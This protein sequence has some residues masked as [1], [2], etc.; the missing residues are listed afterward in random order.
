M[1]RSIVAVLLAACLLLNLCPAV[2]AAENYSY[3]ASDREK[4]ENLL[5]VFQWYWTDTYSSADPGQYSYGSPVGI[6]SAI[7]QNPLAVD[8]SQYPVA[9]PDLSW[10]ARTDPLKKWGGYW[11]FD[12]AAV[13][14]VLTY[15]FSLTQTDIASLKAQLDAGVDPY[16]YRYGGSYYSWPG[17]VGGC[18]EAKI[19]NMTQDEYYYRVTYRLHGGDGDWEDMGLRYAVLSRTEYAGEKY[20]SL[21]N[22]GKTEPASDM[23]FLD[24]SANAYYADDVRWAVNRGI[25]AGTTALTFAPDDICNRAQAVTFLWRAAGSP[26]VTPTQSF[27]DV[28]ADAWYANAVNW[29]VAN[30]ITGGV[31][32]NRF[33]PNGI[34]DRAQIITLMYRAA[35]SPPVYNGVVDFRDVPATQYYYNAVK[36][37]AVNGITNGTGD[38]YFNPSIS[39]TR[40]QIAAFLH[41]AEGTMAARPTSPWIGTY[42]AESGETLTVTS[43]NTTSVKLTARSL[44]ADGSWYEVQETLTIDS[45]PFV[46]WEPWNSGSSAK[47][48]YYLKS[49]RITVDWPDGWWPD[50]DYIRIG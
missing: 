13:D 12:E 3:S 11:R 19:V 26:V 28:P 49:D 37:A 23:A 24:V 4:I 31:G 2:F 8:Y 29:A 36:W 32:D 45:S 41:R 38:G 15:V 25:A 47:V 43:V 18:F 22:N 40:G 21:R 46:A 17:G 35:G 5:S 10:N 39:C 20:W 33:N 30:D 6:L 34:C 27:V 48:Y 50:R 7:I 42:Q 16:A 14:W 44:S 9:Q 1:K